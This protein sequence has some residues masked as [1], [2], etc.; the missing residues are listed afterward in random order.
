MKIF[1][2]A[3]IRACDAYTIHAGGMASADLMERAAVACADQ[4]IAQYGRDQPFVVL[5]GMGNNGGDGLAIT[6]I[7]HRNGYGVKAFVVRYGAEFSGDCHANLQRLQA[8][9]AGLVSLMEPGTFITDIPSHIVIIDALF[10]TGLNREPEGWLAELIQQINELPNAKI[11]IDMPSG[12]SADSIPD[13]EIIAIRAD[14]TLSFQFYKRAFLHPETGVF[15]G[16]IHLI[17]IGLNRTFIT[18][19]HTSY[20]IIAREQ[21]SRLLRPRNIFSHKGTYGSA[22]IIAGSHGMMGA[23]LLAAGAA[24]RAGAGKVLTRVPGCGYMLMQ[25]GLPE[26]LCT[27][28]GDRYVQDMS[29]LKADAIGIGPGLGTEEMTLHAFATL[30]ERNK[31]PLVLDADALNMIALQ[32]DLLGK[33]PPG[34]ILTP[35]PKEFERIFGKTANSMMQ[36][37]QARFQA[38]RYNCFIVLKGRYTAI[39]TPEGACWYNLTGNPGMATGGSGDVLTGII[40]GLLAQGYASEDAV[41]TGV[42]LHGLAGDLALQKESPESLIAGDIIDHIGAAFCSLR[43]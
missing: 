15:A 12:L 30:L 18:S 13:H 16:T 4:I 20:Y 28:S 14:Q 40:T 8:M 10:G 11:A 34:S 31:Q 38:M 5:C 29:G 3:Q 24:A 6:R 35:H 1:S 43:G 9:D 32:P 26:A 27:I 19:T 17:D 22:L 23:A 37:E 7:L 39:A 41:L 42:Y 25:L 36:V 21:I 33:L 2:A